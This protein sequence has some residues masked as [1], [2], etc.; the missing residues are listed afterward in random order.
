MEYG[1]PYR[2]LYE[3]VKIGELPH[4]I[5]PGQSERIWIERAEMER[6]IDRGRQAV[7]E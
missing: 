3:L 7:A 2:S 6:L 5:L 4:V 1:P